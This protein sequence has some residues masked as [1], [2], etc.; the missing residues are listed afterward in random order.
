MNY[1]KII[2]LLC[3]KCKDYVGELNHTYKNLFSHLLLNM[4]SSF[5]GGG[6]IEKKM[7][8]CTEKLKKTVSVSLKKKVQKIHKKAEKEKKAKKHHD[9][10]KKKRKARKKEEKVY[11]NTL[12]GYSVQP[13][14]LESIKNI[15]LNKGVGGASTGELLI[16]QNALKF[17]INEVEG[18]LINNNLNTNELIT[19]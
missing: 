9:K 17:V 14:E 11:N 10:E 16:K 3:K 8:T 6:T 13:K 15:L 18:S 5:L 2:H 12:K 4:N 7:D 1:E 19:P